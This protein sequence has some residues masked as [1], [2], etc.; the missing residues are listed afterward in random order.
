MSGTENRK[1]TT[2]QRFANRRMLLFL[3]LLKKSSIIAP[4]A[5]SHVTHER[6]PIPKNLIPGIRERLLALC[7]ASCQLARHRYLPIMPLIV[8]VIAG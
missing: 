1:Q 6:M 4:T 3:V 7:G 8:A 5:G 2:I